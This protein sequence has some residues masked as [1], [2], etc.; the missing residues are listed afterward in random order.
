MTGEGQPLRRSEDFGQNGQIIII[1]IIIIVVEIRVKDSH[2]IT[3][4]HEDLGAASCD[5]GQNG[6]IIMILVKTVK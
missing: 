5:F 3:S 4:P 2:W 6:Q 1:I